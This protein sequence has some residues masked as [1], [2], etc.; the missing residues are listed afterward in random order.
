MRKRA[1]LRKSNWG[2]CSCIECS[3][4]MA[5]AIVVLSY[6]TVNHN[7]TLLP[8][9]RCSCFCFPRYLLHRYFSLLFIVRS[10]ACKQS[11]FLSLFLHFNSLFCFF[12]FT[13]DV[14]S[15]THSLYFVSK[16]GSFVIDKIHFGLKCIFEFSPTYNK[17][18]PLYHV[19]P[20]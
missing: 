14:A 11:I 12:S 10:Q 20:S 6:L 16:N 17:T 5:G 13:F 19:L 8:I 3:S 9:L 1:G 15:H 2:I 4:A 18:N 7:T